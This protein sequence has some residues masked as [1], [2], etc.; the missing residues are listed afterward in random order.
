MMEKVYRPL[1]MG[2][3]TEETVGATETQP[4]GRRTIAAKAL[5]RVSK[6]RGRFGGVVG[7]KRVLLNLH[8]RRRH[9]LDATKV[10]QQ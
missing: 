5:T 2:R 6:E 10:L 4:T 1:A 3:M 7:R 8:S 9:V